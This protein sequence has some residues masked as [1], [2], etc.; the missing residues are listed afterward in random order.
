MKI[1]VDPVISSQIKQAWS[2][3][4]PAVQNRIAPILARANQQALTVSQTRTAPP[5]KWE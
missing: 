1:H 3:L 2:T 4:S 5:H